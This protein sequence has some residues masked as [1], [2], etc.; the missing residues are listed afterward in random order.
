MLIAIGIGIATLCV[1]IGFVVLPIVGI[2]GLVFV[3]LGAI[4]ANAGEAHRYPF[5]IRFVK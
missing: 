3:I 2:I 4:K 1:G 5:T